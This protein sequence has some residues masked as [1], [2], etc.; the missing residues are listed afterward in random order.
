MGLD[1]TNS[2]LHVDHINNDPLDNRASNLQILNAADHSRK[3][4]VVDRGFSTEPHNKAAR[5]MVNALLL[6]EYSDEQIQEFSRM[7]LDKEITFI[8]LAASLGCSDNGLRKA[9]KRRLGVTAPRIREGRTSVAHVPIDE[10]ILELLEA[11][12]ITEAAKCWKVTGEALSN[13]IKA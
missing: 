13:H 4:A 8:K 6:D 5:S 2:N 9:L 7:L 11:G 12:S 3:T 10:L 1:I